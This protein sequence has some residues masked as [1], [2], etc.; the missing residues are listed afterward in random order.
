MGQAARV[1]EARR[2]AIAALCCACFGMSFTQPISAGSESTTP[3]EIAAAAS[4]QTGYYGE[5]G[6]GTPIGI[7]VRAVLA[8]PLS[9]EM[10][11]RYRYVSSDPRVA[12]SPM[13]SRRMPLQNVGAYIAAI[14]VADEAPGY[15]EGSDGSLQYQVEAKNPYGQVMRSQLGSADVRRCAAFSKGIAAESPPVK[16]GR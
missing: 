6:D 2:L 3:I 16:A 15:L 9:L 11:L 5:C 14:D 1:S 8:S 4:P 12:P 13:L 10:T 7:T